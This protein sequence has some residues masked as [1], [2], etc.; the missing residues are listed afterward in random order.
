M[1]IVLICNYYSPFIITHIR[2]NALTPIAKQ[3]KYI[4]LIFRQPIHHADPP[5]CLFHASAVAESITGKEISLR[6][7]FA[8]IT[9]DL[10]FRG[11]FS[12]P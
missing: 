8:G 12:I 7:S 9:A 6:T 2:A 1:A 5:I 4:I 10:P 3:H 11:G